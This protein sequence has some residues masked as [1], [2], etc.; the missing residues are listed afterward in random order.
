[1]TPKT[2]WKFTLARASLSP[3]TMPIGAEILHVGVQE[4]DICFW[5]KVDPKAKTETRLFGIYGTGWDIPNDTESEYV[6]TVQQGSFVW[7]IFERF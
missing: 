3:V 6:G 2:I 1:M 7:H 5:A 4:N